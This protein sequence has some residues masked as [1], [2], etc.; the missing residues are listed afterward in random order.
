MFQLFWSPYDK[1]GNKIR[2]T[3]KEYAEV[4]QTVDRL[5]GGEIPD[6]LRII[7]DLGKSLD[8][9]GD[10]FSVMNCERRLEDARLKLNELLTRYVSQSLKM[11][12]YEQTTD[13]HYSDPLEGY[14]VKRIMDMSRFQ[15]FEG[16]LESIE[17]I[18]KLD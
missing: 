18:L 17:R 5:E 8:R 9:S 16:N 14:I 7:Q 3:K 1:A 12:W 11:V 4:C 10:K 2:V 6:T 13:P 15:G